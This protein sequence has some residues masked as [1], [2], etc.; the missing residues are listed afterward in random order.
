MAAIEARPARVSMTRFCSDDTSCSSPSLLGA[1]LGVLKSDS[2]DVLRVHDE[3]RECV[4]AH[5]MLLRNED[6]SLRRD[7]HG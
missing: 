6:S 1:G 7:V 4:G 2:N 3:R 5:A